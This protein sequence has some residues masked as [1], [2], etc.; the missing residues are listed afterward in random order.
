L[1]EQDMHQKVHRKSLIL[2]TFILHLVPTKGNN[3]KILAISEAKS[4]L[5][6]EIPPQ[7]PESNL[8]R[9][10]CRGMVRTPGVSPLPTGTL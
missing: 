4:F 7:S 3:A 1:T 9:T 8:S 6:P 10:V 5:G 2:S